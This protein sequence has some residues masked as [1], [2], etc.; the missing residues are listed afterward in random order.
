MDMIKS[1][2]ELKAKIQ[3]WINQ[4]KKEKELSTDNC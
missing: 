1:D 3:D 4:K 2:V